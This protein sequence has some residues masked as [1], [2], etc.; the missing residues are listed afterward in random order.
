[1]IRNLTTSAISYGTSFPFGP[2]QADGIL[3]FKTAADPNGSNP[4]GLYVYS[5]QNDYNTSLA[6]EQVGSGWKTAVDVSPFIRRTGDQMSGD[7]SIGGFNAKGGVRSSISTTSNPGSID[8]VDGTGVVIGAA[9]W[10]TSVAKLN[11]SGNWNFENLPT[12]S[13]GASIWTSLND[14]AGSGL[15]ADVL[16]GQHGTYYLNLTNS[17]GSIDLTAKTTGTLPITRGGTG[18]TT[19]DA[20]PFALKGANTD[21]LSLNSPFLANA[22]ATTQILGTTSN[23]VATCEFVQSA[24]SAGNMSAVLVTGDSQLATANKHYILV[25]V[26]TTTVTLPS[27]PIAGDRVRVSPM[28][29]ILTNIINRNGLTIMNGSNDLI[30]NNLNVTVELMY[31]NSTWYVTDGVMASSGGGGSYNASQII[32][33]PVGSISAINVQLGMAEL[34]SEKASLSQLIANTG[35]SLIGHFGGGATVI[36]T[37][38]SKLRDVVCVFDYMTQAQINDVKAG[39]L[40]LD[41]SLAILNAIAD[42]QAN[43]GGILYFPPGKY[44]ISQNLNV[45]WNASLERFEPA[46]KV[47]LRGAGSSMTAFMDYRTSVATGACVNYDFS[48]SG[49]AGIDSHILSTWT[50]G[51]SII[52]VLNGTVIVNGDYTSMGTG[53]GFKAN[54][55]WGGTYKDIAVSG[56]NTNLSFIDC[57]NF[58]IDTVFTTKCNI[59]LYMSKN[60]YSPAIA[61]SITNMTA[62]QCK[63]WG[64]KSINGSFEIDKSVVI[65]CGYIGTTSGGILYQAT[66]LELPIKGIDATNVHFQNNAGT[67]DLSIDIPNGTSLNNATNIRSCSFYRTSS[68]IYTEHNIAVSAIGLTIMNLNVQGCGFASGGTYVPDIGRKYIDLSGTIENINPIYIGNKYANSIEEPEYD[69]TKYL[70]NDGTWSSPSGGAAVGTLNQVLTNG[71]TSTNFV[72][73]SKVEI[74]S[75]ALYIQKHPFGVWMDICGIF[76]VVPGQGIAP[77]A[78]NISNLGGDTLRWKDTYTNQLFIGTD[79]AKIYSGSANLIPSQAGNPERVEWINVNDAA[80]FVSPILSSTPGVGGVIPARSGLFLGSTDYRWY[81]VHTTE[82]Y[83]YGA[84]NWNGYIIPSPGG[85]TNKFLRDDGTWAT[86][87]GGGS[88]TLDQVL[89]NGNISTQTA[90]VGKIEFTDPSVY[91]KK[92]IN[93]NFFDIAGSVSIIPP[94]V[95]GNGGIAPMSSMNYD[96]GS[97]SYRW[98]STYTNNLNVAAGFTWGSYSITTPWGSTALFL[99]NDGTWAAPPSSIVPTLA[100]VVSAG[101]TTSSQIVVGSIAVAGHLLSDGGGWLKIV[102]DFGVVPGQGIAPVV[103]GA[104]SCGGA[105]LRWNTVHAVSGSINT[106]DRRDKD[107]IKPSSLGLSFIND[108]TPVSYTWKNQTSHL[109][110]QFF[111]VIAQDVK[112][113]SEKHGITEFAGWVS[114]DKDKPESRQGIRYTELIAPLIKAVQELSAQNKALLE[115]IEILENSNK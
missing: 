75:S 105:T 77:N 29:G 2:P 16:D 1:M 48:S 103:D 3:F 73:L 93:G 67:A 81:Q 15:D 58:S 19:I 91:I 85:N 34:D 18:A 63:S 90:R 82:L 35:S 86:L 84:F 70:C 65:Y 21:I 83:T 78:T 13:G 112:E 51:F 98:L 100:Q 50:G 54:F 61:T 49:E 101:N 32:F 109:Q 5:F 57:V 76:T 108:L 26:G 44:R 115:R 22:T 8:F 14:G 80:I 95:G 110:G 69:D 59:G 55:V 102:N 40:L 56:F 31:N 88:A 66:A 111:G 17:T 45:N 52:R 36:R 79:Q 68:D 53:T 28:N 104:R 37:A 60:T 72:R 94:G 42:I 38:Q 106:S 96:N 39:T 6:G 89:T 7:L 107:N 92:H 24:V 11:L 74:T 64:V 113:V 41:V 33:T 10:S 30:L 20:A 46:G 25:N 99:R 114:D 12:V 71:N 4:I 23:I 62:T 43:G 97:A 9:G 27:S 87:A 47:V